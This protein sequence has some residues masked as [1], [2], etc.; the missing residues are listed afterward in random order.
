M[1]EDLVGSGDYIEQETSGSDML[2]GVQVLP[3]QFSLREVDRKFSGRYACAAVS[4]GEVGPPSEELQLT[5]EYPPEDISLS[6]S[7]LTVREGDLITPVFCEGDS[8]PAPTVSWWRHTLEVSGE[9][10]LDWS[11]VVTR[12]QAGEYQCRVSN[13]HGLS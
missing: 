10:T 3:G 2:C 8:Q 13:R 6:A 5:V 11:E 7:S 9:A 4:G 12:Q 1:E